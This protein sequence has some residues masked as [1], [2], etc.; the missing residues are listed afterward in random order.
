MNS[1]RNYSPSWLLSVLSHAR[2]AFISICPSQLS[3]E[4]EGYI[5][6]DIWRVDDRIHREPIVSSLSD[7]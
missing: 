3:P 1:W 7:L 5:H 2:R 6:F 4:D